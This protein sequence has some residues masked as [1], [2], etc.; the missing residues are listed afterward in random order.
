MN[1]LLFVALALLAAAGHLFAV[2]TVR[3]VVR[4]TTDIECASG[5]GTYSLE[6]DPSYQF[7]MLEG[8]FRI[9]LDQHVQVTGYRDA[10]SGCVVLVVTEPVVLLPPLAVAAEDVDL[11]PSATHLRQNYPNPFNPSTAIEYA[12]AV[13]ARVRLSVVNLLGQEVAL[14]VD[15]EQSPGVYRRE[16]SPDALPSGVYI[17]RLG[18]SAGP[19]ARR[20]FSQ[21]M[22]LV[23]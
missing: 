23:R 10:C 2:E 4:L 9:Y 6:P 1:R 5:S 18:V 11:R 21:R 13:P 17:C 8:N 20:T 16:W 7:T 14:L 19:G 22:L 15:E 3:G 12:L